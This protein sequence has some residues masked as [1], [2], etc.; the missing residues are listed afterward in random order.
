MLLGLQAFVSWVV[1]QLQEFV[2]QRSILARVITG[3]IPGVGRIS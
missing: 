2:L 1:Q 3:G